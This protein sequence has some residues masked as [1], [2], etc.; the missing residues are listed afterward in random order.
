MTKLW[1][2]N[3]LTL[4]PEIFP[5]PLGV[6]VI[7]K[8]LDAGIWSYQTTQIRDYSTDNYNSVDDRPFGGGAGMVMRADILERALL[9]I[10]QPGRKICLSPRGRPLTQ[11]LVKEISASS[12]VTLLCG[13]YEGVD[14]RFLQAYDFEEISVGDFVMAGGEIPALT[15]MEACIRLLPSVLGNETT[16]DEESFTQTDTPKLE[17][18]HYTRPARWETA[19]GRVFD[20]PEI[21]RSGDHKAIENWRAE[22]AQALTAERRPDLLEKAGKQKGAKT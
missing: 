7:G 15:L 6:S 21:L 10:D 22:Q 9:A 14:E 16:P 18:P 20:V 8:A 12:P 17:Y 2:A 19:D 11:S 1:H 3:I 13:R 5:G 4:F